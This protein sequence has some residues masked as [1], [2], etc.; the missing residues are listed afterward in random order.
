MLIPQAKAGNQFALN[1]LFNVYLSDA[2]RIALQVFKA[3][4]FDLDD[5]VQECSIGLFKAIRDF[6]SDRQISFNAF[7]Q[8]CITR[9]I[10]TALKTSL[11]KKQIPLNN[12]VSLEALEETNEYSSLLKSI[13]H[14][15]VVNPEYV[16][17][18][19]ED[20]LTFK[21]KLAHELSPLEFKIILKYMAGFSYQEIADELHHS[22]KPIDNALQRA[23][24]KLW[25]ILK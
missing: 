15:E 25:E 20:I 3:T 17:I 11:R 7:I 23:K 13:A 16:I 8:L 14:Q 10:S 21:N 9:Q 24:R 1:R 12:Y 4:K 2:I 6:K 18:E 5:A 22:I 19:F